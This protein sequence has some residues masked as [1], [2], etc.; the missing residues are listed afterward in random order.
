[1]EPSQ[2]LLPQIE[3]LIFSSSQ[4]ITLQQIRTCLEKSM[5]QTF[6]QAEILD[7]IHRLQHRYQDE[8]FGFEL[9]NISG[10][11]QFMTKGANH[12]IVGILLKEKNK[13][14][15][16]R[17][18]LETLAIIAYKQPVTKTALEKIRGVSCDYALQKLLEKELV[19]IAGRADGPGRPLLYTT[20]DKFMDYFGLSSLKDMPK[21]KE[22]EP[23]ENQIGSLGNIE[24]EILVKEEE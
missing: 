8:A 3:A 23:I 21:P 15:L 5:E 2:K 6:D 16:S 24:E 10:G 11:Y 12:H 17:V 9:I 7:H 18:A 22:F 13:K 20:S 4:A 14:R 1:M 19:N